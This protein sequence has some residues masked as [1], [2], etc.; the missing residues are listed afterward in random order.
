VIACQQK[1]KQKKQL[2]RNVAVAINFFIF[3][4]ECNERSA[5]NAIHF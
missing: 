5:K 2:K 4:A 3:S 1:R